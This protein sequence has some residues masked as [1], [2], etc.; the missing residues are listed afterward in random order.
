MRRG[1]RG[2]KSWRLDLAF[3]HEVA[4][5]LRVHER[6]A[7]SERRARIRQDTAKYHAYLEQRREEKRRYRVR[8]KLRELAALAT[9]QPLPVL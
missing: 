4:R 1:L 6:R 3:D 9:T 8:H 2:S 5:G 7:M